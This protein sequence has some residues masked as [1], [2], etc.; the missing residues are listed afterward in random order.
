MESSRGVGACVVYVLNGHPFNRVIDGEL[1]AMYQ[2]QDLGAIEIYTPAEV[3]QEFRVK[4]L[5][6]TNEVGAPINGRTDCTTIVVWTKTHLG[7]M[8]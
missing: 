2:P 7:I 1:D 6:T 3:P 4:T 5:P 8:N